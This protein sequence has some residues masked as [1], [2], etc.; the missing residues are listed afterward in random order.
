[1]MIECEFTFNALIRKRL[2]GMLPTV[3]H[4]AL[5]PYRTTIAHAEHRFLAAYKK[6]LLD[7]IPAVAAEEVQDGASVV[8]V[9]ADCVIFAFFFVKLLCL[10]NELWGEFIKV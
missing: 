4:L 5:P 8:A 3:L 6:A 7:A 1:M 2:A 10:A 9:V